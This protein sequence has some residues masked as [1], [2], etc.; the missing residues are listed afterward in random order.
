M[1]HLNFCIFKL[2]LN[3]FSYVFPYILG[4]DSLH[5]NLFYLF[6]TFFFICFSLKERKEWRTYRLLPNNEPICMRTRICAELNILGN[7]F[8]IE[9][10]HTHTQRHTDN[11]EAI[12]QMRICWGKMMGALKIEKLLYHR[13]K[14]VIYV[15]R[16]N[17]IPNFFHGGGGGNIYAKFPR[18]FQPLPPQIIGL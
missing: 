18:K 6:A 14:S 10:T 15:G 7:C 12:F 4:K 9:P 5:T 13:K 1:P 8:L 11:Q 3:S 16:N 2:K 17:L